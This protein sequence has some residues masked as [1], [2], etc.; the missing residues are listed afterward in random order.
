MGDLNAVD[1]AQTAHMNLI[2]GFGGLPDDTL[3]RYRAPVPRGPV[4]EGVI[5][6]DRTV[7]S[8]IPRCVRPSESPAIQIGPVAYE[9]VGL[10]RKLS[11]AFRGATHER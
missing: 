5:I 3:L 8:K 9:A 1:Y 2:R 11:K 4:W 6:D 10:P 7:A